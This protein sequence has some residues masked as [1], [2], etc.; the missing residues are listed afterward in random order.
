MF[1]INLA[2]DQNL[3]DTLKTGTNDRERKGGRKEGRREGREGREK[4]KR[5]RKRSRVTH[6]L[7][8]KQGLLNHYN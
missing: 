8:I 5:N 4:T 7:V 6:K 1:L 2:S 3:R